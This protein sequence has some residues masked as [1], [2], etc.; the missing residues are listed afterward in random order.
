MGWVAGKAA[1]AARHPNDLPIPLTQP[2][3]AWG[4]R[5]QTEQW[6]LPAEAGSLE[7]EGMER[8]YR[9][10]Q[11]ELQ[12]AVDVS[13]ARKAFDLQL[14]E[15]GPYNVNYTSNG[16]CG[17]VALECLDPPNALA[18][19]RQRP[20]LSPHVCPGAPVP[21][22]SA[23]TLMR[24]GCV[25]VLGGSAGKHMVLGSAKGHLAVMEW[26]KAHLVTELQ[27]K[28]TV[29]DVCFLHN[30]KFFAAAQRKYVYIYDKRG[31]EIHCLREH[32]QVTR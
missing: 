23:T 17:C 8:T 27:V 2:P 4:G 7:A 28:E 13:T 32:S 22:A 10:K 26:S 11:E 24:E 1:M 15:L 14:D 3:D 29:R 5:T 31:L 19:Q 21:Q 20:R 16:A 9:F 25:C 6:L 18:R 12:Q 30:D